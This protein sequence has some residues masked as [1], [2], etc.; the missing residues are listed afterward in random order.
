MKRIK[1]F[2]NS[3]SQEE[4]RKTILPFDCWL[5]ATLSTS[6]ET[7][8]LVFGL[9]NV[10]K[11]FKNSIQLS[12]MQHSVR[13]KNRN[14]E[15]SYLYLNFHTIPSSCVILRKLLNLYVSLFSHR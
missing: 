13:D 6:F 9:D 4:I 11:L 5:P 3:S 12:M 8:D 1:C 15:V 2:H 10:K 7:D 14:F